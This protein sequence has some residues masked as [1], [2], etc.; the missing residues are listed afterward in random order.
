MEDFIRAVGAEAVV[1]PMRNECCGGYVTLED[2]AQAQRQAARVIESAAEKGAEAII[3][4]CPLCL[5]NLR[6]S[7]G[8]KLPVVYFTEILAEALG[9]GGMA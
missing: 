1:F 6:E 9:V 5:Y 7:A 4:A 8:E 2:R 3:T